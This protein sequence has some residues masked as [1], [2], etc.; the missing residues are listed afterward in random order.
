MTDVFA[1]AARIIEEHGFFVQ[2]VMGDEH[3]PSFVYTVG[4]SFAREPRHP[5]MVMVGFD[6]KLSAQLIHDLV[7]MTR[8]EGR[9]FDGPLLVPDLIKDFNVAVRPISPRDVEEHLAHTRV[10]APAGEA[11]S[12][13][14]VI[15]PDDQGRFAWE[16][17]DPDPLHSVQTALFEF[18]GEPPSH[19]GLK[20][21]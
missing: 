11:A 4:L 10:H 3:H 1:K 5:E 17:D 7:R 20:P 16:T 19:A 15:L 8:D 18:V 6:P 12:A 9:R 14:Q 13:V 21:H 2:Y